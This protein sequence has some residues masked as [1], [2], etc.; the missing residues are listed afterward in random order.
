MS[1]VTPVASTKPSCSRTE[2]EEEGATPHHRES[3]RH[4][5]SPGVSH[6]RR[7]HHGAQLGTDDEEEQHHITKEGESGMQMGVMTCA[8]NQQQQQPWRT[9]DWPEPATC[10]LL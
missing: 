4:A 1:H 8:D 10:L 2:E 3:V 9:H 7:Q 5:T 6:T